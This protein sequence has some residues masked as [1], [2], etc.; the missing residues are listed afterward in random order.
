MKLRILSDARAC[1]GQH[2]SL[3]DISRER[4]RRSRT[5]RQNL[6][7]LLDGAFETSRRERTVKSRE[8]REMI[9]YYRGTLQRVQR[10]EG[11]HLLPSGA[12]LSEL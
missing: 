7:W 6:H 8:I 5:Q 10:I 9:V 3:R 4:T 2:P 1:L 11:A 12:K